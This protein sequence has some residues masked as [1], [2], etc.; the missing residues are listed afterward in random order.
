MTSMYE[1]AKAGMPLDDVFII[2]EHCHMGAFGAHLEVKNGSPESIIMAM[3]IL[4]IDKALVTHGMSLMSDFKAGNDL[5]LDAIEKYPGRFL[6]YCTVNPLYPEELK[7]ELT[8]CFR[9]KGMLGIK[10]HP[11][12]HERPMSYKHYRPAFTFAAKR[13][14]FVMTHTY[15]QE[16]IKTTDILAAEFPE[17]TFIMA[18]TGGEKYNVE[19]ALEV[20][21][22]HD[23]VYGD[24]AVSQSMEGV[25]EWYVREVG[26]KKILFGTDMPYMSPVATVALVA[27]SEI[28]DDEKRD[29]F[30]LNMQRII[31]KIIM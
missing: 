15:T 10:L 12:A 28:S 31:D 1:K 27:M 29:I 22:R 7:Q 26:S 14:L 16:D 4:G 23:N 25:I 8:R 3:D 18:H 24:L 19:R 2:D 11:Y 17:A 9:F 30:G 21:A 5:V 6:G 20:I 13:R